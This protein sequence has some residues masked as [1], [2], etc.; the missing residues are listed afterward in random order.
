MSYPLKHALFAFLVISFFLT[1]CTTKQEANQQQSEAIGVLGENAA[2][3]TA[4]PV[5]SEVGLAVLK[6]GG[7]AFDA[8][9]AVQFALAV[10][11]PRAG[12]IGG[13]G[14]AV[15]RLAAGEAGSLDFREKAPAKAGRDMYLD[16]LGKVVDGLS[17]AGALASGVPGSVA[18]MFAL[19]EKF[20]SKPWEYLLAPAVRLA[21]EGVALTAGE[22]MLLNRYQEEIMAENTYKPAFI[23]EK[24]WQKGDTL[25]QEHLANTLARIQEAGRDGFYKGEVAQHIVREMEKQGGI[26]SLEDLENYQS[27]WRQPVTGNYKGHKVI[28]MPP[29]SSGGIALLQ[30]LEGTAE[31]PIGDWGHN[32]AKTIHIMTELERRVYADRATYLG[33]PDFYDVPVQMLLSANYLK[34]R[35]G[36]IKMKEKTPSDAIKEGNVQIIESIETTHFSIVDTAGNAVSLTTTLNGNFGSKVVVEGA[37]F[38]LNNEMDDF[39][40]KP[41]VPNMFGLVGGEANKIEPGKRMLSSMTPTI[42]EKDGKLFMVVGTPGGSTIITSVYQTILNVID[43]QMN[44]QQAINARKT[45]HQWLPDL[46][47]IENGAIDEKTENQLQKLGHMLDPVENIGRIEGILIRPDGKLEAAADHTRGDDTALA[48]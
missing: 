24:E 25:K 40:A 48:F 26:I 13:G 45:H 17:R 15:Y 1:N 38:F 41:G 18:G 35:F 8:A 14:F 23:R 7:N 30:L 19:H 20:G 3:A 43:H 2:V 33:D 16:G 46:I 21:K 22:A 31:Y 39:S 11:Y 10:A 32:A 27:I 9:I 47:L 36:N 6:D 42:V 44:M 34:E 4:H 29:P 37:G 28:S 5:A 12:N